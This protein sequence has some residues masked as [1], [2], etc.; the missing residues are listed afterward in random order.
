MKVVLS[1]NEGLG[2]GITLSDGHHT[3]KVLEIVMVAYT[4]L[5]RADAEKAGK[6]A[7]K[8]DKRPEKA[9]N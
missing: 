7:G 4:D 6:K 2:S 1:V 5:R 3:G 8:G 9:G